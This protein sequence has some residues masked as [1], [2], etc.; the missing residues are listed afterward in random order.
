MEL[1]MLPTYKFGAP[2]KA[3]HMVETLQGHNKKEKQIT[4]IQAVG[5][6]LSWQCCDTVWQLNRLRDPLEFS[7][8]T[9]TAANDYD[10]NTGYHTMSISDLWWLQWD[11]S[12]WDALIRHSTS[13]RQ[14][15][16]EEQV[17]YCQW[18]YALWTSQ[19]QPL[20]H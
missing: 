16:A 13:A 1:N 18:S 3:V 15:Q 7:S 4:T 2:E 19:F 9:V 20:K 6:L 14:A 10:S 11:S 8:I 17:I 5:N 12:A